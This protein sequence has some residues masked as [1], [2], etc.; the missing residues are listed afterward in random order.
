LTEDPVNPFRVIL[1]ASVIWNKDLIGSNQ[2]PCPDIEGMYLNENEMSK[3][4]QIFDTELPF[5]PLF[6]QKWSEWLQ[7]RTERKLAKYR[8]MGLKMAL[9]R[10]VRESND[11]ETIAVDMLD[12]SM[13]MNYQGI[14]KRKYATHQRTNESQHRVGTSDA[15]IDALAKW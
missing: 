5:G 3:Q 7:Y 13:E 11:T 8:P 4:T 14:F 12:F 10:I 9:K 1:I 2:P 15:R 6:A